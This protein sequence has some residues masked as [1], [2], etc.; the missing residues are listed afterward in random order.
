MSSRVWRW[1]E[2]C[3][4]LATSSSPTTRTGSCT[5]C[6]SPALLSTF[7]WLPRR[8][9]RGFGAGARGAALVGAFFAELPSG[10]G[11]GASALA[12][13]VVA[14]DG[15]GGTAGDGATSCSVA[16]HWIAARAMVRASEGWA[17]SR[18]AT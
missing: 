8:G 12:L 18:T 3:V 2:A 4:G 5:T 13:P 11:T 14:A 9:G 10:T 6:Q 16:G 1:F 7:L 17:T 15:D